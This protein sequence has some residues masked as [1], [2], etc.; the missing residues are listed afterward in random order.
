MFFMGSFT[1]S[2]FIPRLADVYGRKP[3]YYF[4]LGL[5]AITSI[6]YPFSNSLKLNYALILL[7]GI[8]EAGRYYV[9]FVL[10]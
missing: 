6:F 7:G 1:G 3:L 8:S 4:G 2:F 9:G 5:Y 10:L